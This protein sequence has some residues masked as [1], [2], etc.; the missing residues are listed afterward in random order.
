MRRLDFAYVITV[1]AILVC[2]STIQTFAGGPPVFTSGDMI[3]LTPEAYDQ[4]RQNQMQQ[5]LINAQIQYQQQQMELQRQ[6]NPFIG[7]VMVGEVSGKDIEEAKTLA[8]KLGA[9]AIQF[10]LVTS[11]YANAKAFACPV[12]R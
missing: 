11:T 3:G 12:N 8:Q 10:T 1:T 9:N 4:I 5:E 7:C 2:L 6:Q